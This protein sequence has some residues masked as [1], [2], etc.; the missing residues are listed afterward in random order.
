MYGLLLFFFFR[1]KRDGNFSNVVLS[2]EIIASLLKNSNF[3]TVLNPTLIHS[4]II[5]KYSSFNKA[6]TEE[7]YGVFNFGR[8][9]QR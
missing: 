3:P 6:A 1:G 4:L 9:Y 2:L 7:T 8:R 5:Q